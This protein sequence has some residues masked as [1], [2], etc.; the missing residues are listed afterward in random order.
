MCKFIAFVLMC[1]SGVVYSLFAQQ[2]W[3]RLNPP[4]LNIGLMDVKYVDSLNVIAVG[5]NGIIIQSQDGGCSWTKRNS[6]TFAALYEVSFADSQTGFAV[7]DSGTVVKTIDGGLTWTSQKLSGVS[8]LLSISAPTSDVVTIVGGSGKIYRTT[9][10]GVTWFQQS[11]ATS[12]DLN[13]VHFINPMI[14][15]IGGF[16]RTGIKDS[17]LFF[18]TTDGGN[19]WTNKLA[20]QQIQID[21]RIKKVFFFNKDT[22]WVSGFNWFGAWLIKTTDGGTTWSSGLS[23]I[24]I[25]P[26]SFPSQLIGFAIRKNLVGSTYFCRTT[27]VGNTWTSTYFFDQSEHIYAKLAFINAST[28]IVLIGYG[29]IFT[30]TDSDTTWAERFLGFSTKLNKAWFYNTNT[31][32]AVGDTGSIYR[33]TNWGEFWY[34]VP[35]PT[36]AML[37][38]VQF[39][40]EHYGIAVGESQTILIT[41][42]GGENWKTQPLFASASL[43]GIHIIDSLRIVLTANGA[44]YHTW[45]S[46]A[47]WTKQLTVNQVRFRG[48]HFCDANTGAVV[49]D[50]G[51]IFL[52]TDGGITWTNRPSGTTIR[53][54]DVFLVDTQNMYAV[55][56]SG[57]IIR[58]TNGGFTWN[59]QIS[60]TTK[61]LNSVWFTTPDSGYIV[62]ANG[63]IL[64]TYNKGKIWSS[65]ISNTTFQLNGVV[66]PNKLVGYAVGDSGTILRTIDGGK[67]VELKSFTARLHDDKTVLL[68]WSTAF[69]MNNYGFEIE[70]SVPEKVDDW[71]KIGFV[72]GHG[73]ANTLQSYS[74][75]DYLNSKTPVSNHQTIFYRLKQVD[76]D[77]KYEYSNVVE[78]Q[79]KKPTPSI[80]E[81][82]QNFPNPFGSALILNDEITNIFYTIRERSKVH[83]SVYDLL[84]REVAVLV[85]EM[86]DAGTFSV[87]FDAGKIQSG[88]H[89]YRLT[90]ERNVLIKKMV[91]R[92]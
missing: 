29:K 32:V 41:T 53:L 24:Y 50:N 84:G 87:K 17:A 62:G 89:V 6:N 63:L 30:T 26:F 49:G 28:G 33:T 85:D 10:G 23:G 39:L 77:G 55:G 18:V 54:N 75:V 92:K 44:I 74:F 45:N 73:T 1:C 16:N 70:R 56:D 83:L 14:G 57:K 2:G 38:D 46:G 81:L 31:G 48:I 59:S 20:G 52:T 76:V 65:Q 42:D 68:N 82:Y 64:Q 36:K 15:K 71:E 12:G 78:V 90:A 40:N 8:G 66:F 91:V 19:I 34:R 80:I 79:L 7:G 27:D 11:C 5:G 43:T 25:I 86:R 60:Y 72:N 35:T 21:N 37:N 4:V 22:G 13:S 47:S 61:K 69:E 58:T 67:P 3:V 51:M 9:N 88:V